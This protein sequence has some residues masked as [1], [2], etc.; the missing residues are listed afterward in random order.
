MYMYICIHLY[1]YTCHRHSP[2]TACCIH[3][4]ICAHVHIC[5]HIYVYIHSRVFIYVQ[6][7]IYMY[8]Y[9]YLSSPLL[10]GCQL[11]SPQTQPAERQ[12]IGDGGAGRV[13]WVVGGVKRL[14][15]GGGGDSEHS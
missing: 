5:V 15:D 11:P 7:Y 8:I 3:T 9:I 14:K 4:Y 6:T 2:G 10:R 1:I 12:A 13:G